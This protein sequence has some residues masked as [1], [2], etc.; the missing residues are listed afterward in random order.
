MTD[1][2]PIDRLL[3]FAFWITGVV[4]AIVIVMLAVGLWRGSVNITLLASALISFLGALWGGVMAL[5]KNAQ[6]EAGEKP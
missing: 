1:H 2:S 6:A 5:M 3:T 4:G